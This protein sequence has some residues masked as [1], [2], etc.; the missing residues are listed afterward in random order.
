M[1][2]VTCVVQSCTGQYRRIPTWFFQNQETLL[3]ESETTVVFAA[4]GPHISRIQEKYTVVVGPV[5]DI[6]TAMIPM[7]KYF[8]EQF[9]HT[10]YLTQ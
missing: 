5:C 1:N 4:K 3:C 10:L 6:S 8:S 2:L 9:W 7:L